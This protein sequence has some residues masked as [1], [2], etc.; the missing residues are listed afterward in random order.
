MQYVSD[1]NY[2]ELSYLQGTLFISCN[3][4]CMEC[5]YKE[6]FWYFLL[7]RSIFPK[8]QTFWWSCLI[9]FCCSCRCMK[10]KTTVTN[11]VYWFS[12]LG[13]IK[14]LFSEENKWVFNLQAL[15]ACPCLITESSEWQPYLTWIER[16]KRKLWGRKV[17]SYQVRLANIHLVKWSNTNLLP[18]LSSL[19]DL[20]QSKCTEWINSS[21]TTSDSFHHLSFP[22]SL[23]FAGPYFYLQGLFLTMITF[24]DLHRTLFYCQES[25]WRNFIL[26]WS[27]YYYLFIKILVLR[28]ILTF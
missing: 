14:M 10:D 18:C 6:Y 27:W 26:I 25:S 12:E 23:C 16:L 24:L 15:I 2:P 8:W 22:S 17:K 7:Q 5:L 19:L 20:A 3:N 4:F 1:L 9:F 11:T 21:H 13:E 28:K